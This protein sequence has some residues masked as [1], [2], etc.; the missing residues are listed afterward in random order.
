MTGKEVKIFFVNPSR[1]RSSSRPIYNDKYRE[2][3]KLDT[4]V[5]NEFIEWLK[6]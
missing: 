4:A 6:K 1:K 2:D 3:F 5:Y